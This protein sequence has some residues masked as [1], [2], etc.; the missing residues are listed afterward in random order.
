MGVK[1]T[2]YAH[3]ELFAFW[4][5]SGHTG[6]DIMEPRL[7]E[8]RYI[9]EAADVD[10]QSMSA[11]PGYNQTSICSAIISASSISIP[12]YRTVLSILVRPSRNCTALKLPVRR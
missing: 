2:R 1:R 11:L 3:S 9:D 10:G 12:R 7:C 5:T 4:S 6:M 8:N